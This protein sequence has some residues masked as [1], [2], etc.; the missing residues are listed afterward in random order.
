MCCR[1][2]FHAR[3]FYNNTIIVRF[4]WY[5]RSVQVP[6]GRC[7][8]ALGARPRGACIRGGDFA[9]RRGF[10]SGGRPDIFILDAKARQCGRACVDLSVS[11]CDL[12]SERV[13]NTA[14]SG[15]R[16]QGVGSWNQGLWRLRPRRLFDGY[17]G[18]GNSTCRIAFAHR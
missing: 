10:G 6:T 14:A 7:H 8:E 9:A 11:S 12:Q 18:G 5:F 15:P 3:P 4:L 16:T 2:S 1:E 17:A 13:G